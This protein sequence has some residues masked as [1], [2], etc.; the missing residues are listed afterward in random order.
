MSISLSF[1]FFKHHAEGAFF[2]PKRNNKR[3]NWEAVGV[4]LSLLLIGVT[5]Y[6][7]VLA[8]SMQITAMGDQ[9]EKADENIKD[10]IE[11]LKTDVREMRGLLHDIYKELKRG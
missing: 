4:V 8:N 7:T 3:L 2:M 6:R 9:I 10:N 11:D 5:G 1:S